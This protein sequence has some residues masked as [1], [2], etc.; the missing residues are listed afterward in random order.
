MVLENHI[1]AFFR[2]GSVL[3][4]LIIL[5]LISFSSGMAQSQEPGPKMHNV[6]YINSYA[7]TYTWT[8]SLVSGIF[9]VFS[10][11]NDIQLYIEFLDAKRFDRSEF[12]DLYKLYKKKYNNIKFDVA[13]VSDNDALDF[14]MEYG[15]VLIPDIP[16]VFCGINNPEDYNFDNTNFYGILDGIDLKAEI[17]LI[18]QVMPD[19]KK[20]CFIS[21]SSTTTSLLN[22][23]Y[24][25]KLEPEYADRLQFVYI[26]NY[27]LDSLMQAVS[28]FEKG[29]AIALINYYQ[30]KKGNPLN[31]EAIYLEIA[32][33]SPVPIFMESETLLGKGIAGGIF[34]KGRKHG[35]D[36]A[37]LAL[38]FIDNAD[39]TPPIRVTRPE[40]LYYFDYKILKKFDI[41]EKYLPAGSI[42]INKPHVVFIKYLKYIFALTAVI[43]FLLMIVLILFFNIRQRKKAEDLVKQKLEEIR[44]KNSMLEHGHQQVNEMNAKLEEINEH[45]SKTNEEL[46]SARDKSE[47]S[48]RLKSAFLANMSHEIRTPLNAI[49]GFSSLLN[50]PALNEADREYY[51]RIISSNSH[52]LLNI[53]EDILDLSRI[54]AGQLKTY[55]ALFSVHELIVELVDSF[56]KSITNNQVKISMSSFIQ[57]T[58][59]MLK[60][61]PG[62]F[63]QIISNLLSN[64]IKFTQKGVIEI[65]Y[66]L[67]SNKEIT[68]YVKDTGIG[69]E[70]KDL[71]YIFNR[72]WKA[73][74]QVDKFHSGAGLGLSI[75]KRLC[76]ALGSKIRAESEPGVGSAFYVTF[77]DYRI[78]KEEDSDHEISSPDPMHYNWEAFTVAIVENE[79]SNLYLLTRIL[80]KMKVNIIGFKSGVEVVDFFRDNAY[81]KIDLILMDIK[82]PGMDGIVAAKLIREIN[83]NI[84]II[85]QT[86]YAMVEDV[87]KIKSSFDDFISKPIRTGLLIEKVKKF[88]YPEPS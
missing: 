8:D 41:P 46:V 31:P 20:L 71:P 30:D 13:I 70:K 73:E 14:L 5:T 54:E 11:H 77:R 78:R 68:F 25:I 47:E 34:I 79:I 45:L 48:D 40:N 18:I 39:Y 49:I 76:D 82:M 83:P 6:L 63:K 7:M 42:I 87:N 12:Q 84:P 28:K 75:C 23:A 72:F 66:N 55:I 51:F 4:I 69:I 26:C 21:D 43:G 17:N 2:M 86:A 58:H 24:I 65:G 53:I 10:Q 64:A 44:D 59:L 50:D 60:T 9:S 36:I 3:K 85:A 38:K 80:K 37:N 56:S 67:D 19:V 35:R 16:I 74:E 33:K 88:L 1:K 52:Q 22:L 15:D 81:K 57:D 27:S 62:R 61:D 29:T 32:H